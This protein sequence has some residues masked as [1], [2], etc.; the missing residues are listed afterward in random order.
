MIGLLEREAFEI[1]RLISLV[2]RRAPG[3]ARA[4]EL[5]FPANFC[6]VGSSM[7]L[8][9]QNVL[10]KKDTFLSLIRSKSKDLLTRIRNKSQIRN[11]LT[12]YKDALLKSKKITQ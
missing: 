1:A 9:F 12:G 3:T 5:H 4:M 10:N 11:I 8:H 7:V 6:R 2:K